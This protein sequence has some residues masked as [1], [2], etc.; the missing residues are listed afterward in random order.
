MSSKVGEGVHDIY[1]ERA[2]KGGDILWHV[3]IKGQSELTEGIPLHMSLK[4]FED[5]NDMD[6]VDLKEKVKEFDI[7]TP[8]PKKLSFKTT[9]FT[10]DRDAKQYYML[11][12]SGTDK[13][14]EQFYD[15]LRHCG[16][17]YKNF[18]MHVTIDKGLYD[19][20][21]EEGLKPEEVEFKDLSIEHGA[22]NTVHEFHPLEKSLTIATMKETISLNPTLDV[23]TRAIV[24]PI[25]VFKN[26]LQDNPGLEEEILKKHED[27][28]NHH[29][30]DNK[31]LSEFAMKY[32][33]KKTYEFMRKK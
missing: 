4:V 3:T 16:T 12:I 8:E 14:Y 15:S 17:V 7:K 18:M 10:S 21:N 11:K 28:I 9:I 5:K 13:S 26:Y 20:I 19:K 22:G 27:R 2:R 6:I 1:K 24:L 32:G 25:S 30:C 23:H 33:I 31:E 29:F